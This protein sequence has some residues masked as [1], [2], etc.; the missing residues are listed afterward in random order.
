MFEDEEKAVRH[1]ER[2][3]ELGWQVV[4]LLVADVKS[5]HVPDGQ[6]TRLRDCVYPRGDV[7]CAHMQRCLV[8][9][10]LQPALDWVV[11][12]IVMRFDNL[13]VLRD[14]YLVNRTSA[15]SDYYPVQA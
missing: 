13:L 5:L 14:H 9:E 8:I 11:L 3:H 15:H 4:V 6:E 12:R 1:S 7:V 10:A 2:L